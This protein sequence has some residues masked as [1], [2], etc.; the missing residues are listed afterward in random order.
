MELNVSINPMNRED[1]K[2]RR[3]GAS[4]KHLEREL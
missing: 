1:T 3:E 4:G 2:A